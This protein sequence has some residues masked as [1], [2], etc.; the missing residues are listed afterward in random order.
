MG[1]LLTA[2]A[3][4]NVTTVKHVWSMA[5]IEAINN[6]DYDGRTALHVACENGHVNVVRYLLSLE[7]IDPAP[8]DRWGMTPLQE[9][10]KHGRH[11]I[12]AMLE[13]ECCGLY[14]MHSSNS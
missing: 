13:G 9:A 5:G 3:N 6:G 7:N 10:V 8:M 4:G 14:R 1:D 2:A 12:C 11:E